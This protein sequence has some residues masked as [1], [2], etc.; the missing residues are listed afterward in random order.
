L[1][2][3]RGGH[4]R[5]SRR[6]SVDRHPRDG[7]DRRLAL[8]QPRPR[9]FH[10]VPASIRCGRTP[11]L[12]CGDGEGDDD[13]GRQDPEP[14]GG[15]VEEAPRRAGAVARDLAPVPI[16]PAGDDLR[17]GGT[18]AALAVK[19]VARDAARALAVAVARVVA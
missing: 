9:G 10:E 6:A 12:V 17:P 3:R 1:D 5:R 4:R 19:V 11:P 13:R 14:P 15:V 16:G 7:G 2:G 8:D 18:V